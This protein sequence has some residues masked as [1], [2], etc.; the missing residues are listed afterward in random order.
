M[1]NTSI[2]FLLLPVPRDGR[3]E[4]MVHRAIG[5]M[6]AAEAQARG[7]GSIR[8]FY[9]T[10]LSPRNEVAAMAAR[11]A[12]AAMHH[13]PGHAEA[14]ESHQTFEVAERDEVAA[15]HACKS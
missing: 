1:V 10:P 3:P 6:A 13:G 9:G 4:P 11:K 8:P 15:V 2:G 7:R 5:T 14:G 12:A